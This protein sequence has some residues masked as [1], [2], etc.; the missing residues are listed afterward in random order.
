[1][2]NPKLAPNL[3]MFSIII[4]SLN[5]FEMDWML[6]TLLFISLNSLQSKTLLKTINNTNP[7][8]IHHKSIQLPCVMLHEKDGFAEVYLI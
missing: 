7:L 2:A 3:I 8:K 6:R 4:T 1:M 5:R